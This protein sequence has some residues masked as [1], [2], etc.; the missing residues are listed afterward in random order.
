MAG[1]FG[2][3]KLPPVQPTPTAPQVDQMVIDTESADRARRRRGRAATTLA[4]DAK[5][6]PGSLA[7]TTLLGGG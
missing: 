2:K 3:P 4:G 6:S 5:V 7:V 1:L